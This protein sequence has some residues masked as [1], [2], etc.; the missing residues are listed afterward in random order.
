MSNLLNWSELP[1]GSATNYLSVV[2]SAND[3]ELKASVE[4]CALKA[5]QLIE[6]HITDDSLYLMFEWNK[7]DCTLHAVLTDAT[8]SQDAP[9]SVTLKL[10]ALSNLENKFA[11]NEKDQFMEE[12]A[13][14][15][16]FWLH[17]YFSTS[18][19]FFRYSLV[20]IFHSSTRNNT[21]LL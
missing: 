19:E 1:A 4:A 9:N 17:D 15:I 7:E 12:Q 14:K 18:T 20:A 10:K 11:G 21:R 3:D 5:I 16:I 6:S 13:E 2:D 8:K